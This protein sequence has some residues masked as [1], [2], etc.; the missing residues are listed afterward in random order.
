MVGRS[1]LP[2]HWSC[3]FDFTICDPWQM[4]SIFCLKAHVTFQVTYWL[5]CKDQL[6][7][8]SGPMWRDYLRARYHYERVITAG[9]R[10]WEMSCPLLVETA[11]RRGAEISSRAHIRPRIWFLGIKSG[12]PA[13]FLAQ[14]QLDRKGCGSTKEASRPPIDLDVHMQRCISGMPA[15][16]HASHVGVS[17]YV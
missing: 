3:I 16:E 8:I 4:I 13:I 6:T 15:A 2:P 1:V 5:T 12:N 14:I 17:L 10:R 7:Y 11:C 9:R